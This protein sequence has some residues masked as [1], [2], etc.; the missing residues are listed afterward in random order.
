MHEEGIISNIFLRPK[1]DGSY[2]LILNLK[3]FNK[4]VTYHFKID[5]LNTIIKLM[6]K[7][8]FMASVDL[9][10]AYYSI[11]IRQAD[12]KYL[13]FRWQGTVYQFTCLPNGLT[14]GPRKFTKIFKPPLTVLHK[15]GHILSA[16][17]DDFYLQ[18]KTYT[19]C[20]ENVINTIT[21]F[22][23]LGLSVHPTK[24]TLIPSQELV[25]KN[26]GNGTLLNRCGLVQPISQ[27]ALTLLLILNRGT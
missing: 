5:S 11:A 6:Q 22:S 23:Q 19:Q 1:K 16:H 24:S 21:L 10:D 13:Q 15:K 12:Q 3:E 4:N 8:C 2:R 27:V 18:G 9:K 20:V 17:L 14:S 26:C 25:T 7:D